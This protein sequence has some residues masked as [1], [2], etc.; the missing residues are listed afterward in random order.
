M[1]GE[2][3]QDIA[4]MRVKFQKELQQQR[5]EEDSKV[6]EI[7]RQADEVRFRSEKELFLIFFIGR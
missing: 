1:R 3:V 2:H 5:T 7:R 6:H 4:R